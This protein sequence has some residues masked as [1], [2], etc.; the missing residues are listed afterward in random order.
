MNLAVIVLIRNEADIFPAFAQHLAALFDTALFMDHG[1]TDGTSA[2]IEAACRSHPGNARTGW[3]RWAVTVPGLHQSLFTT[4]ALRHLFTTTD[5]EAVVLLDAD[6]FIDTQDRAA[7]NA[8]IAAPRPV[9]CVPC[10]AWRNAMPQPISAAAPRFG[11]T[12]LVAP[13][14][15]AFTKVIVTRALYEATGGALKPHAGS[16]VIDPGDG[17]PLTETIIGTL[18][19]LPLRTVEQMTRKTLIAALAHLARTDRAPH[20]GSHRF[21]ALTRIAE[22][23]FTEAD[24]RGWAAFYGEKDAHDAPRSEAE[25]R[26]LGFTERGLDVAH[27]APFTLPAPPVQNAMSALAAALRDWRPG[28]SGRIT[29]TLDGDVLRGETMASG[30]AGMDDAARAELAA[31]RSSK[32]WRVTAPLRGIAAAMSGRR[33]V[34]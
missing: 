6:E 33:P 24:L 23:G 22:A 32:S 10:F 21:D 11:D 34:R 12:L 27:A 3:R 1:S 9:R 13:A 31:M 7:L 2:M 19:H 18:L 4:F 17:I 16:H 15:S 8:A 20:E 26:A 30:S 29:L 14:P 25:L 28:A 5:A